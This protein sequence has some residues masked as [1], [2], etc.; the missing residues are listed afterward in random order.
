MRTGGSN[1]SKNGTEEDPDSDYQSR[2]SND[3][4]VIPEIYHSVALMNTMS[5]L[6]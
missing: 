1:I 3:R 4:Y 2:F 5:K 6:Y